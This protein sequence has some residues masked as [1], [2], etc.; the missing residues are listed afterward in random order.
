MLHFFSYILANGEILFL[1]AMCTEIL[2]QHCTQLK[3]RLVT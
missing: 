2:T 3:S 1:N